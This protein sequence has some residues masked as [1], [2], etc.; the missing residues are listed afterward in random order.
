MSI[1]SIWDSLKISTIQN[2][3]ITTPQNYTVIDDFALNLTS[4]EGGCIYF[5][6]QNANSLLHIERSYFISCSASVSYGGAVSQQSGSS[7]IM[8]SVALSCFLTNI[9]HGQS[10]RIRV[11]SD[12]NTFQQNIVFGCGNNESSFTV[13]FLSGHIRV[14]NNN[15]THNKCLGYSGIHTNTDSGNCSQKYNLMF[16][17]S[18]SYSHYD[19]YGPNQYAEFIN[20]INNTVQTGLVSSRKMV[21]LL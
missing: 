9:W 7:F 14:N 16:S 4:P 13:A 10:F 8:N 5:H 1:P 2:E 20:V 3:A 15:V 18:D 21:L 12:Q 17:N 19:F 6:P 11:S